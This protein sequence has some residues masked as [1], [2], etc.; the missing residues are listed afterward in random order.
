MLAYSLP[1]SLTVPVR[2]ENMQKEMSIYVFSFN[3]LFYSTYYSF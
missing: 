1:H 3:F 2:P